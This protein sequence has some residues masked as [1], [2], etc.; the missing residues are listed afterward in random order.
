IDLQSRAGVVRLFAHALEPAHLVR[1]LAAMSISGTFDVAG[2]LAPRALVGRVRMASGTI[3]LQGQRFSNLVADTPAVRIGRDGEL[4]FRHLSGRWRDR[5]FA[6][7]GVVS[8]RRDEI[9]VSN[10]VLD[11]AGAHALADARYQLAER[12]LTLR[13]APLS[14]SPASLS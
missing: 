10:A 12:H 8:W 2:R 5:P 4:R 3:D 9:V 13:A 7:R 11:Y 14:L 6:A 1:G